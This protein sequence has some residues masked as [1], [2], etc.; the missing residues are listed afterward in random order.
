MHYPSSD[1]ELILSRHRC[2]RS[3]IGGKDDDNQLEAP[4]LG[5]FRDLQF[6]V[7]TT[8]PVS[9]KTESPSA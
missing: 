7:S 8:P 2:A 1:E 9:S 5:F 3:V 6:F 4:L